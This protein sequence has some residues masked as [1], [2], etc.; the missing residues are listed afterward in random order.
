MDTFD[1]PGGLFGSLFKKP[2]MEQRPPPTIAPVQENKQKIKEEANDKVVKF[3]DEV[4]ATAGDYGVVQLDLE[5]DPNCDYTTK[6]RIAGSEV[7]KSDIHKGG[8][9]SLSSNDSKY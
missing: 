3:S 4:L 2:E 6:V 1:K 8:I 7:K 5:G 9:F